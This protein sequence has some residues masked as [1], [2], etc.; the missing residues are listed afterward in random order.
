VGQENGLCGG[1]EAREL[2]EAGKPRLAL[3][4]GG[5][6]VRQR[7]LEVLVAADQGAE[8]LQ[9]GRVPEVLQCGGRHVAH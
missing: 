5:D 7:G 8:A 4:P 3:E 9:T 6:A 2:R 1:A